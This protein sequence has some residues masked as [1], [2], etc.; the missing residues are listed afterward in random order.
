MSLLVPSGAHRKNVMT[1][2]QAEL[3][4][5]KRSLDYAIGHTLPQHIPI[6]VSCLTAAIRR[7]RGGYSNESFEVYVS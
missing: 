6:L 1:P 5:Q 2:K 7:K 3:L 4:T